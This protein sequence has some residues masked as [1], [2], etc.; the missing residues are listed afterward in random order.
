LASWKPEEKPAMTTIHVRYESAWIWCQVIGQRQDRRGRWC[1]GIR[2]YA[3]P[4][5]GGR[6]GWF[7]LGSYIRRQKGPLFL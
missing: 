6:E 4:S 7:L 3:S 2:W 1:V 5:I